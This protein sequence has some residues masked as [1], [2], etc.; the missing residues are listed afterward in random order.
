MQKL[1]LYVGS[2]SREEGINGK[3][4][5]VVGHQPHVN[6]TEIAEYKDD[7]DWESKFIEKNINQNKELIQEVTLGFKGT[8]GSPW[9]GRDHISYLKFSRLM[10]GDYGLQKEDDRFKAFWERIAFCNFLQVPDLNLPGRSGKDKDEYYQKG[11]AALK[12][13]IKE[14]EPD[15][16]IVWGKHA[17]P[18]VITV[19]DEHR[20]I[21]GHHCILNRPDMKEKNIDVIQ[22]VHP[23]VT[24]Y[25]TA[26]RRINEA[27]RLDSPFFRHTP[28]RS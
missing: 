11:K 26:R 17:Y 24:G 4:V 13:Y 10:T 19:Y 1:E 28:A 23:C 15:V 20:V 16:I 22:I 21:N 2:M 27:L 12:E 14:F 25:D 8:N 6:D 9:R 3:R 18:H 7:S 5:L